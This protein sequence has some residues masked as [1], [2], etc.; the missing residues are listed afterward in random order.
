M[1]P[2]EYDYAMVMTSLLQIEKTKADTAF[3]RNKFKEKKGEKPGGIAK[4][5][6]VR[7][8]CQEKPRSNGKCLETK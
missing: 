1:S 2:G 7:G 3:R 6:L 5:G 4:I 8:T